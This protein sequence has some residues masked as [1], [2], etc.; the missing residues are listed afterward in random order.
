MAGDTC[1]RHPVLGAEWPT[2]LVAQ[3]HKSPLAFLLLT[4]CQM[5]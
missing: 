1:E 2:R 4:F 5:P 3:E